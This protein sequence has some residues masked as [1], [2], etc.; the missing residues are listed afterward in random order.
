V[1]ESNTRFTG[2][3]HWQGREN[4][5]HSPPLTTELLPDDG[6]GA[7][8]RGRPGQDVMAMI[9]WSRFGGRGRLAKI[10]LSV[11]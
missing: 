6:G 4:D 1:N 11:I 9:E 3:G 7:G 10:D 8:R 5:S 2:G